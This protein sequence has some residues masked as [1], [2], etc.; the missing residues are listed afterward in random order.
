MGQRH[1]AIFQLI[2]KIEWMARAREIIDTHIWAKIL[3]LMITRC[4]YTLET[5][6]FYPFIS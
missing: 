5:D 3:P 4:E 6:V 2:Y 1:F